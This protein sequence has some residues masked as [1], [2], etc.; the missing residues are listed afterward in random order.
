MKLRRSALI[1]AA[2]AFASGRAAAD[3]V[4]ECAAAAHD[5]QVARDEG[6][7][8][9]AR[10][11]FQRCA[12]SDCPD[13]IR[14]DCAG[15]LADVE[16]RTPT[17]VVTVHDASGRDV[18]DADVKLDGAPLALRGQAVPL[19]PGRHVFVADGH[20]K[21]RELEV[22]IV[23]HQK[24]RAV[25]LV[26]DPDPIAPKP[27]SRTQLW[28]GWALMGAGAAIAVASGITFG[29][30]WSHY[31]GLR[32]CS[33]TCSDRDVATTRALL[34]ATD[35]TAAIAL[36]TLGAGL[37]VWLTAPKSAPQAAWSPTGFAF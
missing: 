11:T 2:L 24:A 6:K 14:R 29:V 26:F 28:T 35:V 12:S 22:L 25:E 1:V 7:L 9:T 37:I 36:V 32:D 3:A 18:V 13:A 20:G 4:D 27:A 34:I 23:E 8:L 5:G 10:P 31:A 33:P 30:A 16:E 21:H 19:D 15:W 17:V